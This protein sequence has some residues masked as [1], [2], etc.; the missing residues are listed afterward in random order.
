MKTVK[1]I[2]S[3]VWLATLPLWLSACATQNVNPPQARPHTG[4]VDLHVESADDLSWDVARFDEGAQ[5]L[6]R[7]FSAVKPPSA[8][9]LRLAF[10]PGRCRLQVTFL[11]RPITQPAEVE[12]EVQDGKILPILI[13]FIEAGNATVVTKETSRGATV[14][15]RYGRN[16]KVGTSETATYSLSAVVAPPAAYQPKANMPYAQ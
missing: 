1:W 12:V 13:K 5:K 6:R 4:Y 14:Y 3:F 10:A 11:N 8:G 7:V 15:G 9:V 16:T 2:P